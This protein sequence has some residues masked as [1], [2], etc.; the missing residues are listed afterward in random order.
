MFGGHKGHEVTE[1]E[2]A[3]RNLRD[4]FDSNIKSGKLRFTIKNYYSLYDVSSLYKM[5]NL[6]LGKLKV[7][8]TETYLVDIR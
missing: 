4:R 6:S 5:A 3:V 1:P 2:Q 8:Y 7:E